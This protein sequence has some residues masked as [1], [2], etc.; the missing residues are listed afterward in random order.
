MYAMI[1][2]CGCGVRRNETVVNK[3]ETKTEHFFADKYL[4]SA[5]KLLQTF[6]AKIHGKW[7]TISSCNV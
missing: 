5:H 1:I 6:M 7:L 3:N 4:R 2:G